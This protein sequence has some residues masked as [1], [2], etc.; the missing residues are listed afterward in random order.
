VDSLCHPCITT[1][2]LSYS[3]LSLKLPPPPC[4]VLLV[5]ILWSTPATKKANPPILNCR[6]STL[7]VKDV[8]TGCYWR[9]TKGNG[10]GP[11]LHGTLPFMTL[12]TSFQDCVPQIVQRSQKRMPM[13]MV[14]FRKKHNAM[15][16]RPRG[17]TIPIFLLVLRTY[18]ASWG[19]FS[20]AVYERYR[21][22]LAPLDTYLYIY[23]CM[24]ICMYVCMYAYIYI[25]TLYIYTYIHI[26]IN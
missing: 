20:S 8:K 19:K 21:C 6:P 5:H 9:I 14:M 16:V 7:E 2:H 11:N 18:I 13:L 22:R 17:W 26:Y 3:V 24:Y 1:T 25:Y 23:I 4:A 10:P 15:H 12:S